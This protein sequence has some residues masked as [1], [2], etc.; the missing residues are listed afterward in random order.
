MKQK[1]A[2]F[3]I[4]ILFCSISSN[5]DAQCQYTYFNNPI[6]YGQNEDVK[7]TGFS[8]YSVDWVL[9]ENGSYA[10]TVEDDNYHTFVRSGLSSGLYTYKA[11]IDDQCWT[12]EKSLMK[13][14]GVCSSQWNDIKDDSEIQVNSTD[15]D[16]YYINTNKKVCHLY[17]GS[18]SWGDGQLGTRLAV[19]GRG[20]VR[21][22][23]NGNIYFVSKDETDN[24]K[25]KIY[26]YYY[27]SGWQ[28]EVVCSGQGNQVRDDSELKLSSSGNSIYYINTSNKVCHLYKN[29]STWTDVVLNSSSTSAISGRGLTVNPDNG[30]IYYVG[31]DKDIHYFYWNGSSWVE[32]DLCNQSIDVDS[33]SELKMNSAGNELIYYTIGKIIRHCYKSGSNW[34]DGAMASSAPSIIDGSNFEMYDNQVY[35]ISGNKIYRQ[36][37]D[38]S[39]K[40]AY[41]IPSNFQLNTYYLT[42]HS[43]AVT[44]DYIYLKYLAV[45]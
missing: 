39:W 1:L 10:E 25:K 3:S 19:S 40:W 6:S 34:I 45:F 15:T 22:P 30:H 23:S 38:G 8:Y 5:I 36:Y 31:T 13:Y 27:N 28:C 42:D 16:V 4:V 33:D 41:A 32:N 14:N 7:I 20:L 35:Y 29:G 21:D 2:L 44:E 43:L 26:R 11:W 24:N 12:T 17:K 9:Y 18:S 37:Y